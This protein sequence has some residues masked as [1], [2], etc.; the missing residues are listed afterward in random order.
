MCYLLAQVASHRVLC[1]AVRLSHQLTAQVS[2]ER[3]PWRS[4]HWTI[5]GIRSIQKVWINMLDCRNAAC[6]YR[7]AGSWE[8]G[9]G[10]SLPPAP[11]PAWCTLAL[12]IVHLYYNKKQGMRERLLK[13]FFFTTTFFFGVLWNWVGLKKSVWVSSIQKGAEFP[14]WRSAEWRAQLPGKFLGS[15]DKGSLL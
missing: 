10:K 12:S 15:V 1:H 9:I 8:N 2:I 13:I 7:F 14:A 5:N 3:Q 6:F 11:D 4:L